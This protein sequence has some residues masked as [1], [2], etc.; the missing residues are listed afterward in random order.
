M[1]GTAVQKMLKRDPHCWHLFLLRGRRSGLIRVLWR[2]G[3]GMGL[4][5]KRLE[6]DRFIGGGH[7]AG[8]LSRTKRV[9]ALGGQRDARSVYTARPRRGCIGV[10]PLCRRGRQ[11][12]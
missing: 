6:R 9:H 1:A 10:I 12:R 2:D 3:Q 8:E 4:Y 11:E 7:L 5:A